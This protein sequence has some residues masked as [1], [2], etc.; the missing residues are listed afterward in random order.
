MR[1]L[2]NGSFS[3]HL[4][5]MQTGRFCFCFRK[6]LLRTTHVTLSNGMLLPIFQATICRM[7]RRTS[8][9]KRFAPSPKTYELP[10]NSHYHIHCRA[11]MAFKN[12]ERKNFVSL[13]LSY[14]SPVLTV[15][16]SCFWCFSCRAQS[17]IRKLHNVR[18]SALSH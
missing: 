3:S 18:I 12:L 2:T 15:T 6:F 17:K 11:V 1:P 4:T 8:L 13:V 16:N 5:I 10:F 7:Y 14:L 9:I